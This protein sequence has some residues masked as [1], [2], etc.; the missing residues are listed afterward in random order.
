MEITLKIDGEEKR[1]TQDKVNFVTIQKAL[2]W[3]NDYQKSIEMLQKYLNKGIEDDQDDLNDDDYK[4]KDEFQQTK[5]TAELI[6]S[7]F[8]KQFTYDDLING[9][10][11]DTLSDFYAFG[12]NIVNEI[13]VLMDKN[14]KDTKKKQ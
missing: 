5:E 8:D 7:Y 9:F 2:T 10:Y 13:L 4:P 12:F 14:N 11:V 1:F 3:Y 6:V